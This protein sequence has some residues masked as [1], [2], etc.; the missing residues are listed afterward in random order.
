MKQYTWT[1]EIRGEG[2]TEAEAF[3][4][5]VR[6]ELDLLRHSDDVPEP[7]DEEEIDNE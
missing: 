6:T 5:A 7:S 3:E 4:N 2:D 1:L